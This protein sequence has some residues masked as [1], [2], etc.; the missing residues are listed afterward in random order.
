MI[1]SYRVGAA[2][3]VPDTPNTATAQ[4]AADARM[5]RNEVRVTSGR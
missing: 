4:T 2:D 5:A 1:L 3:A